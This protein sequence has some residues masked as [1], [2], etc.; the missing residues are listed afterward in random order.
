MLKLEAVALRKRKLPPKLLLAANLSSLI[1]P[2][3][4]VG[5]AAAPAPSGDP[6]AYARAW[7]YS[8]VLEAQSDGLCLTEVESS[9]RESVTADPAE[10]VSLLS[11]RLAPGGSGKE[12]S[13]RP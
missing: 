1:E 11:A 6:L 12:D 5:L 7:R 10:L 2:L 13:C 9:L 3:R 8:H 4:S